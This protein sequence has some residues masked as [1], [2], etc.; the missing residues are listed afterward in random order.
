MINTGF[1][2]LFLFL[3]LF[4]LSNQIVYSSSHNKKFK[5]KYP[6]K[7]QSILIF[8]VVTLIYETGW[9]DCVLWC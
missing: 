6:E 7:P 1:S 5:I 8:V 4:E 2:Y 3:F 9:G